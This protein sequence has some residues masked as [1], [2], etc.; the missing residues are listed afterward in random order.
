[1]TPDRIMEDL[2]SIKSL[3]RVLTL[4]GFVYSTS[5]GAQVVKPKGA[6]DTARG[7]VKLMDIEF[8]YNVQDHGWYANTAAEHLDTT[9]SFWFEY[10][11]NPGTLPS[12][13]ALKTALLID[14]ALKCAELGQ[15]EYAGQLGGLTPLLRPALRTEVL[16]PEFSVFEDGVIVGRFV[17]QVHVEEK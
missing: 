1:M 4:I 7:T 16:T 11:S 8:N 10:K 3:S 14:I 5:V 12:Q 6:D 2:V 15:M 17:C 9:K 13:A